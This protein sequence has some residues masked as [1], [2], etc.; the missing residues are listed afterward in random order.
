M[1]KVKHETGPIKG[2]TRSINQVMPVG[3]SQKS[4]KVTE[5]T[6]TVL[7]GTVGEFAKEA[8]I[9]ERNGMGEKGIL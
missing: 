1:T 5:T 6:G 8:C 9:A 4:R 3:S 2:C 7:A